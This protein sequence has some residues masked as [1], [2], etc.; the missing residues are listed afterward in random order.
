LGG[1]SVVAN[2]LKEI[3]PFSLQDYRRR[4]EMTGNALTACRTVMVTGEARD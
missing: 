4:E 3:I 1:Q 2:I